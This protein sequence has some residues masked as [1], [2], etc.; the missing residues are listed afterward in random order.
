[1]RDIRQDVQKRFSRLRSRSAERLSQRN[2]TS[3]RQQTAE[4]QQLESSLDDTYDEEAT[5]TAGKKKFVATVI[6][7]FMGAR[8]TR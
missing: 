5:P 1:M 6:L 3:E 2:A 4:Q 8:I 7:Q